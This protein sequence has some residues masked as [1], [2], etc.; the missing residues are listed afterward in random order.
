MPSAAP[1]VKATKSGI[2]IELTGLE[3]LNAAL[4]GISL[5][6]RTVIIAKAVTEGAKPLVRYIKMYAPV[7]SGALR[8]SISAKTLR[9]RKKGFAVAMVGPRTGKYKSGKR[10]KKGGNTLD[11]DQPSRYA[12]LVEFGHNRK[13]GG[14]T[15]ARPFMRPAITA[16]GPQVARSILNGAQKGLNAAVKKYAKIRAK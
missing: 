13:K 9:N 10:V 3:E 5:D 8:A 16:A 1:T 7:Q 11:S 4:A 12:H 15:P 2:R 14:V 6:M